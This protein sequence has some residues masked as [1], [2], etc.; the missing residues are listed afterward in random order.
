M[1]PIHRLAPECRKFVVDRRFC[2][3]VQLQEKELQGQQSITDYYDECLR[4]FFT[5]ELSAQFP[6]VKVVCPMLSVDV[7]R[8]MWS[9]VGLRE[10]IS[11]VLGSTGTRKLSTEMLLDE[12]KDVHPTL[13]REEIRQKYSLC[14]S[15][16]PQL[17]LVE[18]PDFVRREE[19]VLTKEC[20]D[21][22]VSSGLVDDATGDDMKLKYDRCILKVCLDDVRKMGFRSATFSSEGNIVATILKWREERATARAIARLATNLSAEVRSKFHLSEEEPCLPNLIQA[23]Q[24]IG[25]PESVVRDMTT[26]ATPKVTTIPEF[27][28]ESHFVAIRKE[29]EK[30]PTSFPKFDEWVQGLDKKEIEQTLNRGIMLQPSAIPLSHTTSPSKFDQ[31]I[32]QLNEGKIERILKEGATLQLY[33]TPKGHHTLL[34]L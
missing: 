24:S 5:A 20:A 14:P 30:E 34:P 23:Y 10:Q 3:E 28:T 4:S 21:F 31:W 19:Q 1:L 7:L 22:V 15:L 13:S 25:V 32:R 17:Q 12:A 29:K 8:D 2:N 26:K 11:C 9:E 16:A 33:A 27:K 6:P 18:C